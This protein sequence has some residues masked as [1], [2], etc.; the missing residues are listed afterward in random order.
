MFVKLTNES[1]IHNGFQFKSGLNTDTND[2]NTSTECVKGG[3]YFCRID[4]I[5]EWTTYNNNKMYYIWDVIIPDGEHVVD[6]GNKLKAKNIILS[7]RRTIWDNP[8]FY[9]KAVNATGMAIR[10]VKTQP[11]SLCIDAVHADPWSL[12]YVKTQT[13]KMCIEAVKCNGYVIKHVKDKTPK[14]IREA[15][16]QNWRAE[17]YIY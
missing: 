8:E 2:F 6:M 11:E 13:E 17:I 10:Y 14:I 3:L 4:D 5:Y 12:E 7:N 9:I 15:M 16:L 1:C